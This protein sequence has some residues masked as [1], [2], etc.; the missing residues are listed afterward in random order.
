[1]PDGPA[2][3]DHVACGCYLA[4]SVADELLVFSQHLLERLRIA[5]INGEAERLNVPWTVGAKPST[6]AVASVT[7]VRHLPGRATR[8]IVLD[9]GWAAY[10]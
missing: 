6:F 7:R 5:D 8:T 3:D 1:M 4:A 9:C 10:A 2:A